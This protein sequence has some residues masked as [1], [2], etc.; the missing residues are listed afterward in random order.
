MEDIGILLSLSSTHVVFMYM[1]RFKC[2]ILDQHIFNL[3]LLHP[4][5]TL[6]HKFAYNV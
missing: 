6:K 1:N 2:Y 5:Y 3:S 4:L